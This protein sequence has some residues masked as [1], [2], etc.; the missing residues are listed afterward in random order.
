MTADCVTL[1]I[2]DS[3]G[4]VERACL[5]S[6]MRQRHTLALYCYREPRGVPNGVEVRDASEVLPE[7]AILRHERGS[8]ALFSDWFRYELQRRALGTWVD[9]DNYLLA[10]LDMERPYLFG[11]QIVEPPRPWRRRQRESIAAGVLRLPADSPMLPPLLEQF[12]RPGI[13]DWVTWYSAARANVRRLITG[14]FDLSRLPWGTAGPFAVTA[15]A[16]RYGLSSEALPIDVFNPVPWYQARW[17]VDPEVRLEDL[18]TDKTVGV[19]L[20][21]ECIKDFK[22]RPARTGS[23]L[24]R[25]QREGA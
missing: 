6:V 1:W 11:K 7:A 2:G 16:E 22:D 10:R 25:L 12:E 17:I 23:F 15:L 19:H 8:V 9:T 18:V 4:P 20:W 21:N 5:R 3:L 14:N 13:P 24:E